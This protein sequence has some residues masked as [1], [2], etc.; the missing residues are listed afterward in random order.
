MGVGQ[1]MEQQYIE[2][3][4]PSTRSHASSLAGDRYNEERNQVRRRCFRADPVSP[5]QTLF[6][7]GGTIMNS[8]WWD[9]AP[10]WRERH[11]VSYGELPVLLLTWSGDLATHP[12]IERHV[13]LMSEAADVCARN[14]ISTLPLLVCLIFNVPV[15]FEV[16][17]DT[18]LGTNESVLP[19]CDVSSACVHHTQSHYPDTGPTRL[20]TKSIMPTTRRISC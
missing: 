11:A 16:I 17:S 18:A 8:L 10:G 7:A 12:R 15:N 4:L 13:D 1:H 6:G 19:H 5:S 9:P 20:N 14:R 3:M 2:S